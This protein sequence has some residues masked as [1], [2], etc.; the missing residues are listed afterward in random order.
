MIAGATLL[1]CCC[2]LLA[3]CQG[4]PPLD[5]P[6]GRPPAP[7]RPAI[8]LFEETETTEDAIKQVVLRHVPPGTP[9]PQAQAALEKQGFTCRPYS[10][11]TMSFNQQALIPRGYDLPF[12][13]RKRVHEQSKHMPVYCHA[14]RPG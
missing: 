11:W 7:A 4:I 13:A 1:V 5:N 3:G 2:A 10:R 14:A 6:Y 8:L 12:D 9:I